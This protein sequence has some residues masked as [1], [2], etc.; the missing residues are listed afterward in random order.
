MREMG[1]DDSRTDLE[2]QSDCSQT[3]RQHYHSIVSKNLCLLLSLVFTPSK[4]PSTSLFIPSLPL[5][6]HVLSPLPMTLLIPRSFQEVFQDASQ[7]PWP[8]LT[9]LTSTSHLIYSRQRSLSTYHSLLWTLSHS[10][11]LIRSVTLT[12]REWVFMR[13]LDQHP[14]V[15][16]LSLEKLR[17]ETHEQRNVNS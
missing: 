9:S 8:E 14:H 17:W 3:S 6:L 10:F 13:H 4:P 2:P 7:E 11:F 5:V 16:L 15:L 1:G 12:Y